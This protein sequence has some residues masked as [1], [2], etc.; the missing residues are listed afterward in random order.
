MRPNV[1]ALGHGYWGRN[2]VRNLASLEVLRGIYEPDEAMRNEAKI[3]YPNT[4]FYQH[5]QEI[6]ED[7]KAIAVAIGT[8]A[9]HHARLA[10]R[11]MAAGKDVFVEKPLALTLDE[12]QRMVTAAQETNR[13]LM[14]GHLL[15][16]HPAITQLRQWI[17]EGILGDLQYI[18][19]NRLNLGKFRREENILWSF[20]PHDLAILLRLI[21][22]MP[23]EVVATG[24]AYLTPGVADITTT[25]LRFDNGIQ[26][27]IF[28]SWL[29]PY[30][31]QKLVVVGS[32]KM[33]VFDDQAPWDQKLTLFDKGADWVDNVPIPRQGI[34]R[35]VTLLPKEPL[36]EELRHFID[37]VGDRKP[38][39]TDG[40]SGLRVLKVLHAAQYSLQQNGIPVSVHP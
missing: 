21:Q 7:D 26:A 28:V 25:N 20:A 22:Q 35:S 18:Y 39:L 14:V 8:P 5:E 30:K 31:E 10:L 33:V 17:D 32:Q 3:L 11:A 24:G 23:T 38:P 13:V 19:S 1:V 40:D 27:H 2:I 15:E 29:H 37:R 12:G 34:G 9:I 4:L 36:L 6:W 16:Y